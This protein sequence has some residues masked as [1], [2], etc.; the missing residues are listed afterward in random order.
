MMIVVLTIIEGGF[1]KATRKR[2]P[3]ARPPLVRAHAQQRVP[4]PLVKVLAH[5]PESK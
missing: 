4:P 1:D 5:L 2:E 3:I